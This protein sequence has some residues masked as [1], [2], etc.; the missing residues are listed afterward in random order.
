MIAM[1]KKTDV[2]KEFL[3]QISRLDDQITEALEEI[4]HLNELATNITSALKP[5]VVSGGGGSHDKVGDISSLI[6]DMETELRDTLAE[7]REKKRVV[8]A[9]IDRV[10]KKKEHDVLKKHYVHGKTLYQISREMYRSYRS[11]CYIH[12]DA[13]NTV[14]ELLEDEENGEK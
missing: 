13:L 12:G 10:Q 9:V 7:Y 11:V 6:A 4:R 1:G 14:A 3:S 5:D 2:A 8:C